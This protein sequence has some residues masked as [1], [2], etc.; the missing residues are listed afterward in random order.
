MGKK[1]FAWVR[2]DDEPVVPSP[3]RPT[4]RDRTEDAEAAGAMVQRLIATRP[5]D[6]GSLPLDGDIRE[7]LE[8][9]E[10]IPN[11]SHGA[12]KRQLNRLGTLLRDRDLTDIDEALG[13]LNATVQAREDALAALVRWRERILEEADVAIT[14][15]LEEHPMGDRQ[16]IRQLASSARRA[17]ETDKG[18]RAGKQLMAVLREAAGV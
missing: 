11:K 13:G 1:K 4:R 14:A 3:Y 17:P 8:V 18:R 10:R 5:G 2:D 7:A 6:R 12:K 15:F 16:R 9:Y